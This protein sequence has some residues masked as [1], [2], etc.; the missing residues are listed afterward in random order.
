M[1]TLTADQ[2]S[3]ADEEK[4]PRSKRKLVIIA[5]VVLV[6]LGAGYQF[7][8][9]PSGPTAPVAGEV[10][11]LDPIQLNLQGGHYLRL[12][13]ALQLTAGAE[14]ADGSKAL[15]S[16]IALLSGRSVEELGGDEERGKLKDQLE[17][18]LH[19]EYEGDVMG[20]YFTEFVTQ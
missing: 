3:T 18:T 9:K 1:T 10:L 5:V 7:F 20:V 4:A 11:V 12:G 13:L 14:E 6:A 2:P 8:L 17:E 16:A 19:E 15:D